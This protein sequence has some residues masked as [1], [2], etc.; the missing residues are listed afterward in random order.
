M[1]VYFRAR[2]RLAYCRMTFA[3]ALA[4]LYAMSGI[5][6]GLCYGPQLLRLM[7]SDQA[8]RAMSLVS[9]GSWL[10]LGAIGLLYAVM[11]GPPEMVLVNGLNTGCQ[12]LVVALALG[13]RLADRRTAKR[14]GTS[15]RQP[16]EQS[17]SQI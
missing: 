15:W 13:Q 11:A 7:R 17:V 1:G 14:A 2:G 3:N 5:A 9:W 8:R 6:A 4:S 12:A 10:G 16:S